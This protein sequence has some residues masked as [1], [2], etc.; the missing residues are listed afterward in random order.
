M[1]RGPFRSLL[2]AITFSVL[3]SHDIYSQD[4]LDAV[5][6]DSKL[7]IELKDTYRAFHINN[8]IFDQK[9]MINMFLNDGSDAETKALLDDYI[10]AC[11]RLKIIH[12]NNDSLNSYISKYLAS[13]IQSYKVAQQPA[14]SL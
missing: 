5:K 12:F 10:K 9:E 11:E 4:L 13:T 7:V 3:L 8:I 1:K 2:L 14:E 6:N